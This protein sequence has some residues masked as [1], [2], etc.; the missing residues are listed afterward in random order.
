[1]SSSIDPNI[2]GAPRT[3]VHS[4]RV[5]DVAVVDVVGTLGIA[6]LVSYFMGI[7]FLKACV[8]SF[9]AGIVLHRLAGVRTK[10]DTVL[11]PNASS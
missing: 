3:A 1:M 4:Y 11:F 5:F 2:F 10:V 7:S 9:G 8:L 6:L